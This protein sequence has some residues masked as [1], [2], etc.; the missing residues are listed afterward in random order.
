[1]LALNN[2]QNGNIARG[3]TVIRASLKQRIFDSANLQ[4]MAEDCA[5][6]TELKCLHVVAK[7]TT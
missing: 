5:T 4:M 3:H 2:A 6:Q 1:M 7:A